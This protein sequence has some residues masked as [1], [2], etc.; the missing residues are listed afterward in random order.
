MEIYYFNHYQDN[1]SLYTNSNR[2][3]HHLFNQNRFL[4]NIINLSMIKFTLLI[5]NTTCLFS[6]FFFSIKFS[7]NH[8][9]RQFQS[10][11]I[12]HPNLL[13]YLSKYLDLQDN[14]K[15]FKNGNLTS[16]LIMVP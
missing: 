3:T 15:S 2:L 12:P 11:M 14:H 10:L 8:Y 1:D 5:I 9:L 4:H 16:I 6:N 13:K 7:F